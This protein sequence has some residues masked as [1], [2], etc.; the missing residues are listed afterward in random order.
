MSQCSSPPHQCSYISWFKQPAEAHWASCWLSALL[1]RAERGKTNSFVRL[2]IGKMFN[3]INNEYRYTLGC[4]LIRCLNELRLH[5]ELPPDAWAPRL[6]SEAEPSHHDE[7]HCLAT[8][9]QNLIVSVTTQAPWCKLPGRLRIGIPLL[10]P[11][12][13]SPRISKVFSISGQEV[14]LHCCTKPELS[15][16]FSFL[17]PWWFRGARTSLRQAEIPQPVPVGVGPTEYMNWSAFLMTPPSGWIDVE[18]HVS[19]FQMTLTTL[20]I[21]TVIDTS[22]V[23]NN[24]CNSRSHAQTGVLR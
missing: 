17:V 14:L 10:S 15:S 6:F 20:V 9:L 3:F 24:I 5:S 19:M 2:T 21:R 23:I 12:Q 13:E 7:E 1:H 8:L 11:N 4:V 16:V 22:Y 18:L